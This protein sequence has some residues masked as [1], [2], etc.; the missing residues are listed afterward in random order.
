MLILQRMLLLVVLVGLSACLQEEGEVCQVNK[1]CSGD[2]VCNPGTARCQEPS[3][4]QAI[5]FDEG[6]AGVVDD[7]TGEID[8]LDDE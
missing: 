3:T 8:Q 7:D 2:L 4:S 5:F 6:D 1:D